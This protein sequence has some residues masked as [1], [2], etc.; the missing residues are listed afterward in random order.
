MARPLIDCDRKQRIVDALKT[1]SFDALVCGSASD[2]LLLTGYWP[3]IAASIAVFT[4]DGDVQIILPEDEVELAEK[5]SAAKLNPY[6]PTDLA[7]LKTPIEA[8]ADPLRDLTSRLK[9]SKARIG[10]PLN[11]DMQPSSYAATVDFRCSLPCVIRELH[12]QAKH[13]AC[14]D[15]IADLQSRKTARELD[16]MR[17]AADV[18][19]S[20]FAKAVE[21]IQV[22]EREANV[23]AAVQAAF[24]GCPKAEALHRS[25]GFFFCMSG[26]N[27]ALA[28]AAYARTRERKIAAGD[29][30][31]IHA[32]TCADGYWTDVT[33]TYTA[34]NS[35]K[36]QEEMR[37]AIN[38]ARTAAL[39]SIRC[40]VA[41]CDVDKA[42][43]D[44]MTSHGFGK[45]F[46]H[47]T[48]HGVGFAA[49]NPNARPRIHPASPDILDLGMTFN[50]EPAAYFDGYG[51]MRHCDVVAVTSTGAT[52]LT[53]F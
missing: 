7:T 14:D 24:E 32:N 2:V 12:P 44:V 9:L 38:E 40:G 13:L 39:R 34:E 33:R 11:Q 1:S 50:L 45:A 35:S 41:A 15:F 3:V 36:Q 31:M 49:A 21:S 22:G 4:S 17:T 28:S 52:V 53:D 27:S 8:L 6:K 47:S 42:A 30:V 25:Y 48:G 37:S 19:E 43:R 5:T 51:G 23:A 10:L 26:P 18:C 46:R 16:L 29:L 20:G